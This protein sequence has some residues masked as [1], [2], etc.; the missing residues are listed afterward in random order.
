M[1]HLSGV[2]ATQSLLR[3][4]VTFTPITIIAITI[5]ITIII[6]I[7]I[8]TTQ[9]V[10]EEENSSEGGRDGEVMVGKVDETK[11]PNSNFSG[12]RKLTPMSPRVSFSS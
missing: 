6:K 3:T 8:T 7:M 4:E 12:K 5:T 2:Q 9:Q 1:K 11:M 10:I